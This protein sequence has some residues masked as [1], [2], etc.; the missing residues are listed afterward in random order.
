MVIRGRR[1]VGIGITWLRD[2][3]KEKGNRGI[4]NTAGVA[5]SDADAIAYLGSLLARGQRLTSDCPTP[6]ADGGCPGHPI[7]S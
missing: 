4:I 3:I 5:L 7:E 2:H 6:Q 1:H